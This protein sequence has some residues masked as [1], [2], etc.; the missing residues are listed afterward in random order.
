MKVRTKTL[1]LTVTSV[2]LLSACGANPV[3]E[4][5]AEPPTLE[6]LPPLEPSTSAEPEPDGSSGS[7]QIETS[8]G[9]TA[10][11]R[12]SLD[13]TDAFV[14]DPRNDKP[15]ETTLSA[16]ALF[17]ATLENTTPDRAFPNRFFLV[18]IAL[19]D[20]ESETCIALD[21]LNVPNIWD[22]RDPLH[23]RVQLS[24]EVSTWYYNI[25]LDPAQYVQLSESPIA[26][27][28][29]V[30][31][32]VAEDLS[33]ALVVG[34]ESPKAV[35]IEFQVAARDGAVGVPNSQVRVDGN[36]LCGIGG[37]TESGYNNVVRFVPEQYRPLCGPS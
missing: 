24:S 26:T 8:E 11:V 9:Y 5:M 28:G 32:A 31:G 25:G 10:L 19:F 12:Y 29:L 16:S 33:T 21:S 23:C 6:T 2:L 4:E 27:S 7:F 30:V 18:P 15:G 13:T 34:L 35:V 36:E 22:T 14:L 17:E 37:S 1:V 20:A 3:A